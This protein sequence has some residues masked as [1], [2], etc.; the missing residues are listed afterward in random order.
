MAMS[1]NSGFV[2]FGFGQNDESVGAKNNRFKA[3]QGRTYRLSFAWWEIKDG[4]LQLDAPT[5]K[6]IGA[7]RNYIPGVGYILN[8]GPEY[9]KLA[10][11]PPKM[12]IGTVVVVWPTDAKGAIDKEGLGAGDFK[13]QTW[14]FSQ[15][16]Y[17]SLVPVNVEFPFGQHDLLLT[18][19][20]TQYQKMTFAPCKESLLR[21]ILAATGATEHAE[22]LLAGITAA[23]EAVPGE[24]GRELTPD[25]IREKM[26][27]Q[28]GG[29]GNPGGGGRGPT[30]SGSAAQEDIDALVE[31]LL[32]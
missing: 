30:G 6:F 4:K 19:T 5:P 11:N 24:V 13:V 17:Q 25:Q 16:K 27:G 10:G 12:S 31:N 32:E 21:K 3:E 20:D 9:T 7:Q 18:C 14:V 28:G 8:K 29:G 2:S 1:G 26:S 23:I 15:D 22:R